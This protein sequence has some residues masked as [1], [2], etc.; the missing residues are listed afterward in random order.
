MSLFV[1]IHTKICGFLLQYEAFTLVSWPFSSYQ[2]H[3]Y[4]GIPTGSPFYYQNSPYFPRFMSQ[5]E[6]EGKDPTFGNSPTEGHKR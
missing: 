5:E 2:A 4:G 6:N 1:A 3:W